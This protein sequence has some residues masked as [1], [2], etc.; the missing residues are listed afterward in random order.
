[1]VFFLC[2]CKYP[3]N[4]NTTVIQSCLDSLQRDSDFKFLDH[5]EI[6]LVKN[7]NSTGLDDLHWRANKIA[8]RDT[9]AAE[10]TVYAPGDAISNK[11]YLIINKFN[12]DNYNAR[13]ELELPNTNETLILDLVRNEKG[14]RV[15]HVISIID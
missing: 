11:R 6:I 8:V 2:N 4:N 1:M 3:A 13:V 7:S 9:T 10:I 12:T 15:N 5:S 14:W